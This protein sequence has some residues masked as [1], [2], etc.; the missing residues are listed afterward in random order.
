MKLN[1]I[2]K[3]TL[4]TSKQAI[5][6]NQVEISKIVILDECKLDHGVKNFIEYKNSETIKPLC[7]FFSQMSGFIKHFENSN[8]KNMSL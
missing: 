7:I 3:K 2:K 4:H 8:K 5:C 1:L 6:L